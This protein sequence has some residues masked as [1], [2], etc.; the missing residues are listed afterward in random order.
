MDFFGEIRM[1][2]IRMT[3][4]IEDLYQATRI[5]MYAFDLEFVHY[6]D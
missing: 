6:E 4:N 1:N 3:G 5:P 2:F